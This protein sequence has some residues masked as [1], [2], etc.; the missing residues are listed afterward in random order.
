M[1]KSITQGS[2]IPTKPISRKKLAGSLILL[3]IA[4]C[5]PPLPPVADAEKAH[6]TLKAALDVWQK[7]EPVD[8]LQKQTPAIHVNDPDWRAQ[9]KLVKY[10]IGSGEPHG[11]SWRC[12]ATLT[13]EDQQGKKTPLNVKYLIDT[14]PA[15]VVVRD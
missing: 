2:N 13:V 9:K 11:Q 1:S 8:A 5:S 3:L 4:G 15:L 12:E 10:E 7:G 14:D 6:D